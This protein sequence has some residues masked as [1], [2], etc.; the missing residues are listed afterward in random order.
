MLINVSIFT[1]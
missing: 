1:L